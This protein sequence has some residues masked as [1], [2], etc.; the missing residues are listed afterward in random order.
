M[1]YIAILRLLFKH[2][3]DIQKLST[4]IPDARA[5]IDGP[6]WM[7]NR[8][9]PLVR[10]IDVAFPIADELE[11]ATAKVEAMP[12]AEKAAEQARLEAKAVAL[13]LDIGKLVTLAQLIWNV[14]EFIRSQKVNG[15]VPA[16]DSGNGDAID[17]S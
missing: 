14:I 5:V 15:T 12:V 9:D 16:T 13:G 7:A 3:A 2:A 8:R 17:V 4:L 10:I 11:E 1:N 6:K